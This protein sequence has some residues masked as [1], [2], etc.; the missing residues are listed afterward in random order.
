M[1]HLLP[2]NVFS[3]GGLYVGALSQ[4]RDFRRGCTKMHADIAEA[5]RTPGVAIG[6]VFRVGTGLGASSTEAICE[7]GLG[8]EF[9]TAKETV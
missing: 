3:I 1:N 2:L 9:A 8:L 6:C 7:N 4:I 5:D